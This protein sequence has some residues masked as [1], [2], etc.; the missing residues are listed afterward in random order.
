MTPTELWLPIGAVALYLYDSARLIWQNE[1]LYIRTG[2]RWRVVGGS[3]LRL[4]GRRVHLGHPLL[5]QHGEFSVR[6]S[7]TDK[8]KDAV[9][10]TASLLPL[11]AAARPLGWIA[12]LQVWLL[13]VALPL[14]SWTQGAGLWLLWLFAAFYLLILVAL[15]VCFVRR[16]PL[17]LT[18]R[19]FFHVALDS[20][21]CAPFS[22]NVVR[23]ICANHALAGNPILFAAREFDADTQHRMLELLRSRIAEQQAG[24][25][26]TPEQA[27][28][29]ASLLAPLEGVAQRQ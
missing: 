21:A 13:L 12:Q 3:D 17:G 15:T 25:P 9:V 6:W 10:T 23:R 2:S 24:E 4:F 29:V 5:P 16:S 27:G 20:L 14:I 19:Q 28:A 1:L 7:T 26:A 11:F 8:R 22:I 18:T